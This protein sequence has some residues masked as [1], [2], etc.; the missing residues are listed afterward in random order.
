MLEYS[1]QR[2]IMQKKTFTNWLNNANIKIL[3][4]FTE[5]KDGIYLLHLL[6]LLSSEQ[7]PRP[8]KG[9]MRIHFLENNSKVIQFLKSK[10]IHVKLIGPE[11]IVDGDQ[12]L[13]LGLIWIIIL[14]FQISSIIDA[15]SSNEAL[16]VWCQRKTASY[17]NVNVK[18]FSKSW[19]NGLAFNALIHAH[20][21]D[22]I[23]YSSLRHDQPII[24]LNNAFTVAEKHL[25]ILKLLDAEDVA[26]PFPDER[27]I[28]TYVSF[29]YHYFSRQKQGQTVQKR[30]T[31]VSTDELKFQYEH[32]IFE[33]LKWIKLKVTELDDRSFPNSLEKMRFLMNN[34][35][36]FRTTEK[37]PKYREKGI[38][39][40]N[41]FHIRTKQQV[42]NQRAYLPPEGRTLRDL[43]KEWIALEKAEDSRGKAILQ[44][45]LR[46]E[47][48]EQQ[49]QIF[50]KKAAIRE[51]YLRNMKEIIKK[52]DDWQP[53][54]VEQLQA[55]TRKL[56]AIE[57]DMLPQDQRF[58]ALSTMAAEI[59]R[60]NYQDKALI[61]QKCVGCLQ[62]GA[63]VRIGVGENEKHITDICLA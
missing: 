57:A 44:E 51:A 50:L 23:Q 3:D 8:N 55:G 13:I 6:E 15:L 20:R 46:L 28:M 56:E 26:V 39:E 27:S 1:S 41:F 31:K 60:E 9:K 21:P 37:P 49:V 35:K 43:E 47:K 10:Q 62:I 2:M 24:N 17:S 36:V 45:L 18:D 29:Y 61:A 63:V 48:V 58:K 14:R 32:M 4:L 53:D 25:G 22:L 59:I 5:L 54:N 7:L 12:T 30:L 34:F 16:L 33:L 38:I 52:Q 42:N 19:N 11:N 40:A